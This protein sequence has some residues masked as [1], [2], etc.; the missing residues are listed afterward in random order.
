MPLNV[1]DNDEETACVNRYLERIDELNDPAFEDL[2]N[3]VALQRLVEQTAVAANRRTRTRDTFEFPPA[4]ESHA[5]VLDAI[6][7]W[8]TPAMFPLAK[9][10]PQTPRAADVSHGA[11]TGSSA[12]SNANLHDESRARSE[13]AV[14]DCIAGFEAGDAARVASLFAAR[15][16]VVT[17]FDGSVAASAYLQKV[18]RRSGGARMTLHQLAEGTL[19]CVRATGYFLFDGWRRASMVQIDECFNVFN[20]VLSVDRSSGQLL[21]LVVI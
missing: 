2:G 10:R 5:A 7:N 12:T 18:V 3:Y 17:P 11:S 20:Y 8:K 21:S 15:A 6:R 4:L 19:G 1:E 9:V 14:R 13:A 16:R